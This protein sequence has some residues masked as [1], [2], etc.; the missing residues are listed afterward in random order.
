MG[1]LRAAV[2]GTGF[3]GRTHTEALRRLDID[4]VGIVGSSPEKSRQAAEREGVSKAYATYDELVGDADVQVVHITTPNHL[5]FAQASEAL[6]AGKHVM[7]E[8]PLAMTSHETGRLVALAEETGLTAGVN[9]NIRF[10]PL[11]VE[12]RELVRRGDLGDVYSIVGSYVQDWLVYPT[13]YNWR[14]LA[15]RGGKLRAVADI[16]THWLDLVQTITGLK[17]ER[18]CAD[19]QTV[20]PTRSR[21]TDE[22]ETFSG[23]VEEIE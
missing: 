1:T 22:V 16:G 17:V 14:V 21:P 8:K 19:L 23:K 5:H 2:V 10:Y 18:V 9:Y 3:M 12:A 4:V 7:C 6:R 20:H 15:D 11:N 13:D